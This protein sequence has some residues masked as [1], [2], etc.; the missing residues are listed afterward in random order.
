MVKIKTKV[1]VPVWQGE[2]DQKGR[3]DGRWE[4]DEAGFK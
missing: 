1:A 3:D 4:V 2:Q